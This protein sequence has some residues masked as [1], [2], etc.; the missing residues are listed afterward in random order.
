MTFQTFPKIQVYDCYPVVL[1]LLWIDIKYAF[2]LFFNYKLQLQ[3][4]PHKTMLLIGRQCNQIGNLN[5]LKKKI[6][7]NLYSFTQCSV[8]DDKKYIYIRT[9]SI[10]RIVDI[11]MHILWVWLTYAYSTSCALLIYFRLELFLWLSLSQIASRSRICRSISI[12]Y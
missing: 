1:S 10:L 9:D 11:Y 4:N 5:F 3:K 2:N 8:F 12:Y 6:K 7:R